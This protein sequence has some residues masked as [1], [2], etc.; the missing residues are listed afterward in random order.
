MA[1]IATEKLVEFIEEKT[2]IPCVSLAG[3]Y[4]VD[5]KPAWLNVIEGRGYKVWAECTL[6]SQVLKEIL[7]TSAENIY[8]TWVAKCMLG[9]AMSGSMG[10][11][12][13]FAN[14]IA[15]IFAATGQDLA[16]VVEGSMG[17]TTTEIVRRQTE[18]NVIPDLIGNLKTNIKDP[19]FHGDDKKGLYVSIYLPSLMVGTIGGGTNLE[20][21][22]EAL[23]ILGISGGNNG[24]NAQKFAEIIAGAILAG[25]ISLLSSLSEGSLAQSHLKYARNKT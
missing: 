24:K 17:I 12:A 4:D 7:H 16:H 1:T 18:R 21:Q 11:N 19:R 5:K 10:F 14:I 2:G 23:Q 3:N 8:E 13:H 6:T 9:S 25:E 15:A 20:T 22:S